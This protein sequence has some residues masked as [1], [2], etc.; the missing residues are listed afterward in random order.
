MVGDPGWACA[1]SGADDR[2]VNAAGKT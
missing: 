1:F 2:A